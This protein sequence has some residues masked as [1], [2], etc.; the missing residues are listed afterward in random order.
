[1]NLKIVYNWMVDNEVTNAW[2]S[3]KFKCLLSAYM[4]MYVY[5]KQ[6]RISNYY[7]MLVLRVSCL[8]QSFSQLNKIYK[9]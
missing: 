4:H 5:V 9:C 6:K 7:F 3:T 2:P 1:M 8:M